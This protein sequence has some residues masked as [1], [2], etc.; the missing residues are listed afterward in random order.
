MK[1]KMSQVSFFISIAAI[2]VSIM[3]IL[4]AVLIQ[5]PTGPQ[6][7]KGET[8]PAGAAGSTGPM[9]PKGAAGPKG[10]AGETGP[11]G[12][13]GPAGP[14]GLKGPP[15]T[16]SGTFELLNHY[17][18]FGPYTI[19]DFSMRTNCWLIKWTASTP[20]EA[21]FNIS[22]ASNTTLEVWD[23]FSYTLN[24]GDNSGKEIIFSNLGS[25]RVSIEANTT[26]TWGMDIYGFE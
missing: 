24:A 7:E 15:G 9:G 20:E 13:E 3:A 26:T 19:P 5:G 4:A 11:V 8:G 17:A 12:P 2:A 6:G 16:F 22:I 18:W 23:R 25:W 21:S 10:D 14:E 1:L